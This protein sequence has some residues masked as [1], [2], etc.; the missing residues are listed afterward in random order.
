MLTNVPLACLASE[1]V[2]VVYGESRD[3]SNAR[4]AVDHRQHDESAR[5][6]AWGWRLFGRRRS[7]D[8]LWRLAAWHGKR[9]WRIDSLSGCVLRHRRLE[10]TVARVTVALHRSILQITSGRYSWLAYG[11]VLHFTEQV[12]PRF[13]DYG[14]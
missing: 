3:A 4:V 2:N 7:A 11:Q 13:L 8:W 1:T 14:N 9:Y 6:Y 12:P 10:G 5:C